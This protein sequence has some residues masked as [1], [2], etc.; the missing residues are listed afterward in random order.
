MRLHSVIAHRL[1]TGH[2]L[3]F[4]DQ[5]IDSLQEPQQALHTATPLI[6]NLIRISRLGERYDPSWPVNLRIH[7]LSRHQRADIAFCLVLIQIQQLRESMHLDPRVV[8]GDHADIMFNDALSKILPSCVSL[9]VFRILGRRENVCGAEMGPEALGDDGP[10]HEFGDGEGLEEFFLFGD[11]GV[12]GVGVDAVEEVGLFVVV[13]G[14]ED[15]VDYSLEDLKHVR[16]LA[17]DKLVAD[18]LLHVAGPHSLRRILCP[19]PVDNACKHP[20]TC[21]HA[22]LT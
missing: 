21:P 3:L 19:R 15:V 8:L 9:G 17:K 7:R 18:D 22:W 11:F 12:A 2:H 13:G 14:E 1:N 20:G 4:R 5:V 6:E 16:A 10:A